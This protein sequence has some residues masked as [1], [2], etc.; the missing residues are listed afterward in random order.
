MLA[1]LSEIVFPRVLVKW[2]TRI[3]GAA[4][5]GFELV[6]ITITVVGQG[7]V[8]A[9]AA[10]I[11]NCVKLGISRGSQIKNP[12]NVDDRQQYITSGRSSGG[13]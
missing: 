1:A 11:D 9:D 8:V 6:A 12:D 5:E 2:V 10:T 3:K 7:C 4:L 13:R